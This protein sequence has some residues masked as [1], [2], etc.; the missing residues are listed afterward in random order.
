LPILERIYDVEKAGEGNNMQTFEFRHDYELEKSYHPE[1]FEPRLSEAV[2]EELEEDKEGNDD[3][4]YDQI[5][6]G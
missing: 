1:N 5:A 4:G 2:E 3:G 6:Q